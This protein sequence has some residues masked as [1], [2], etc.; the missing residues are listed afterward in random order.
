MFPEAACSS[1]EFHKF[2]LFCKNVKSDTWPKLWEAAALSWV[3]FVE[4]CTRRRRRRRRRRK[5]DPKTSLLS[6]SQELWVSVQ[7]LSPLER[8]F[9]FCIVGILILTSEWQQQEPQKGPQSGPHEGP[10]GTCLCQKVNKK[11]WKRIMWFSFLFVSL[12][13]SYD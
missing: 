2:Y 11:E 6:T 3:I 9:S 8:I 4:F 13:W 12:E 5:Q 10:A 1:L 7:T